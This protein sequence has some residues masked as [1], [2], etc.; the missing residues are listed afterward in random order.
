M[1][2]PAPRGVGPRQPRWHDDPTVLYLL[3]VGSLIVLVVLIVRFY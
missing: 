2:P 3:A 1:K